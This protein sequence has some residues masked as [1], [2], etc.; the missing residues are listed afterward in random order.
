VCLGQENYLR[1]T[2]LSSG[3][4][5]YNPSCSAKSSGLKADMILSNMGFHRA[6]YGNK[7]LLS[8]E[9]YAFTAAVTVPPSM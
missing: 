8:D 4:L 6:L 3:L 5:S 1:I 2:L 7:L 9:G